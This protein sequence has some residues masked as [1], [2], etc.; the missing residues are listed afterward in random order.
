[1]IFNIVFQIE[2]HKLVAQIDLKI[3]HFLGSTPFNFRQYLRS[4]CQEKKECSHM[5]SV[6]NHC[7]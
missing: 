4:A 3:F 2:Y 5:E 6:T 7:Q 1:M